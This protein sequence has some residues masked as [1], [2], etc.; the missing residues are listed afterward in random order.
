[1]RLTGWVLM[2]SL[3]IFPGANAECAEGLRPHKAADLL[4][5]NPENISVLDLRGDNEKLARRRRFDI[6]SI[7]VGEERFVSLKTGSLLRLR[8]GRYL[9]RS[10]RP[11]ALEDILRRSVRV[12]LIDKDIERE[13]RSVSRGFAGVDVFGGDPDRLIVGESLP[14]QFRNDDIGPLV[15]VD[16]IGIRQKIPAAGEDENQS[17]LLDWS[18]ALQYAALAGRALLF[19]AALLPFAVALRT[20]SGIIAIFCAIGAVAM[21]FSAI[22]PWWAWVAYGDG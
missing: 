21:I 9:Y 6:S 22:V 11:N 13:A 17:Q 16:P 14:N 4:V 5:W 18:P 20:T 10:D 19:F 2:A 1:M 15:Q 8:A 12:A 3:L 7:A